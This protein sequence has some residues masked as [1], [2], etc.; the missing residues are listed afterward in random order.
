MII[1]RF[2]RRPTLFLCFSYGA[3]LLRT[4]VAWIAH[5]YRTAGKIVA[6]RASCNRQSSTII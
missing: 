2:D 3:I 6:G 1:K 4:T 5:D